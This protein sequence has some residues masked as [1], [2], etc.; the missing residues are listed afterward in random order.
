MLDRRHCE[1]LSVR[2]RLGGRGERRVFGFQP[3]QQSTPFFG[4]WRD[5]GDTS[6]RRQESDCWRIDDLKGVKAQGV[7]QDGRGKKSRDRQS[8]AAWLVPGKDEAQIAPGS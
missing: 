7:E 1:R 2:Q 5:Y 3:T 8:P 6:R 4:V